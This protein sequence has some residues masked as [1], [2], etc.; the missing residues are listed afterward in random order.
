[1]KAEA[2]YQNI[3]VKWQTEYPSPADIEE[4]WAFYREC[5]YKDPQQTLSK[6]LRH[7]AWTKRRVLDLGCDRGLMLA[8]ICE[9]FPRISGHGIDINHEAIAAARKHFPKH[10]F[11]GFDGVTIPYPEKYFDLV[12]VCAVAKHIR[13]EDREHF[14]RELRRVADSVLLIEIDAKKKEEV[15]QQ[16][17]T[18]YYSNFEQEFGHFFRPIEVV[19][20]AGDLLGIYAS[21]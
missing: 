2:Y 8:F 18:F 16:G 9:Q 13:Y 20:E 11:K 10:V 1:M 7:T 17:W 19:H 15:K 4:V 14:Y 6:L 3:G 12:F 5:G 21:E